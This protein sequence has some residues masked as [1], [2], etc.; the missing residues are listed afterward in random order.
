MDRLQRKIEERE[1][2]NRGYKRD[3][4]EG[5]KADKTNTKKKNRQKKI[6]QIEVDRI[7]RTRQN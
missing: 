6:E 2:E 4:I 3:E 5:I 7:D 1:E